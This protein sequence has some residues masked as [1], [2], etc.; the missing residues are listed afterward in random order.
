MTL[1]SA[2]NRTGN[3]SV[4]Y[5]SE[6]QF[7]VM[8]HCR[9]VSKSYTVGHCFVFKLRYEHRNTVVQSGKTTVGTEM[10]IRALALIFIFSSCHFCCVEILVS[11]SGHF[12]VLM[13]QPLLCG[14]LLKSVKGMV[15][16]KHILVPLTLHFCT[17]VLLP[18]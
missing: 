2:S 10:K 12:F 8:Q 6:Q 1:H 5:K 9:C 11:E 13:F 14:L 18:T 7:G 16:R 3:Y 17:S 4:Y 15:P